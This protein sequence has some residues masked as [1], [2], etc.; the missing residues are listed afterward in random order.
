MARSSSTG[1]SS[2]TCARASR[3]SSRG[4]A[5]TRSR[6]SRPIGRELV[7]LSLRPNALTARW[8]YVRRVPRRG[9]ARAARP[10]RRV[11]RRPRDGPR[12]GARGRGPCRRRPTSCGRW[13]AEVEAAI[14]AGAIGLSSGLIYAPG[15]HAGP[16]EMAALV[17]AAT[18][19]RRPVCDPHPQRGGRVVRRARRG[20]DRGPRVGRRRPSPGLAPQVRVALRLGPRG[21]GGRRPRSGARGGH[22]RRR[23]PVPV[24]G[25]R[26]HPG[27]H[28]ATGPAGPRGRGM[29]GGA[30]RPGGPLPGP[31]GDRPG[32]LRLGGRGLRPRLVRDPHLARGEP[33]GLGRPVARRARRGPRRGPRRTSPSTP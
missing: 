22:R 8:Q 24:H 12:V 17:S 15:V 18:R 29:R 2:A 10:E 13:S 11:P 27:H 28:P 32:S 6:R 14:E 23:R 9:R 19:T 20:P 7:A 16:V 4:T 21:R 26:D 31:R 1:R 3:P 30:R 5:A 33:P 25:R